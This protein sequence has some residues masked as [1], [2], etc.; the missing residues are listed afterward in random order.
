MNFEQLLN[1]TA[2]DFSTPATKKSDNSVFAPSSDKGKNGIYKAVIRF[3]PNPK[4]PKNSIISKRTCWLVDPLTS[5]GKYVDCPS[6]VGKPS[7][8]TNTYWKLKNSES[9]KEQELAKS[10][11]SAPSYYSLVQIIKDENNKENEGKIMIFKYGLKIYNKI[12]AELNPEI[13][14]PHIPFSLLEGRLFQLSI[15]KVSGY[16]NYDSCSFLS[17]PGTFIINSDNGS[18]ETVKLTESNKGTMLNRVGEYIVNNSPV[19]EQYEFKDWND[20]T[21]EYVNTVI[22]NTIGRNLGG[23][24][25]AVKQAVKDTTP[26]FSS[27]LSSNMEDLVPKATS[28]LEAGPVGIFDE[29]DDIYS[30]L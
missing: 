19:L 9:V 24:K 30:D 8:L 6:S 7:P 17:E 29:D 1:L 28:A 3:I 20:E 27:N 18:L 22:N 26:A 21:T 23:E 4:N 12:Q 2:E 11:S 16:N 10:F 13:G 5:K 14:T 25:Q 15:S